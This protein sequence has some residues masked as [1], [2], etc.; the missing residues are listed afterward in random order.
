M[1]TFSDSLNGS[2]VAE[3]TLAKKMGRTV[4][5]T[6]KD[7]GAFEDQALTVGFARD[8][9]DERTDDALILQRA[10][11]EEDDSGI[12]VEIPIQRFVCYDGVKE[13]VLT[14]DTFSVTFYPDAVDEL[15]GIAAMQISFA[16]SDEE[17]SNLV[18]MLRRIF[19][20]HEAFAVTKG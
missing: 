11:E 14:R 5:F 19:H 2:A 8:H 15:G 9:A 7:V 20:D 16:S 4:S 6:A 13:A 3:L 12:Y 10:K 17:F 1:S 18:A